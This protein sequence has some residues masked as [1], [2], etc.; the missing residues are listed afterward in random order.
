[1]VG[2]RFP[3]CSIGEEKWLTAVARFAVVD[4]AL[5]LLVGIAG[6]V[7]VVVVV[8]SVAVALVR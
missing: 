4:I 8:H 6:A 7:I 3:Y 2:L 1:M 5:G